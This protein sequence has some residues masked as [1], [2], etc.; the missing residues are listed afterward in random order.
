MKTI[1]LITLLTLS[2]QASGLWSLVKNMDLE[3]LETKSYQIE[4][5]GTNIR[6]YVFN[7]EFMHSV[8]IT[9]WGGNKDVHTLK[10][11]TYKQMEK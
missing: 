10:C 1:L 3:T 9:V 11:K 4:I 2:A 7:V 8:C 6:A 5:K